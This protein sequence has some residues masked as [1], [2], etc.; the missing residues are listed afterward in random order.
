MYITIIILTFG[1]KLIIMN[2]YKDIKGYEGIYQI[3]EYGNIKSLSRVVLNSGSYSGSVKKTERILKHIINRD[4]YCI[5][6]LQKNGLRKSKSIHRL[7][8]ET[9]INNPNNYNEVNHKDLNKQ[10]NHISNLEWCDRA[11][12]VNHYY[13][14]ANKSSKY[15]GVSYSEDRKK[16]CSYLDINK[17]RLALGRFNTELEAKEYRENFINQLKQINYEK[18]I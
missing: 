2:K 1:K 15:K 3:D 17:K 18:S 14:N 10:N 12:N 16:W 5:V 9:F 8:S 7:V 13:Q 11:Y 6:T 4:G